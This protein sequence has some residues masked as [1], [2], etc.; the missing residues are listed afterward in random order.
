MPASRGQWRQRWERYRRYGLDPLPADAS[1]EQREQRIAELK[2]LAHQ[3]RRRIAMRSG[4][5]TL[6]I[7]LL[8]AVGVYW[9]VSTIGGRDFLLAQIKLRLPAGSEL[10]YSR[11][12]GPVRGPLILHDLRFIHRTCPDRDGEPVAWPGCSQ[13]RLI[14]FTAKQAM[15]HPSLRPLLGRTLFLRALEVDQATLSLP[16][17]D[18]KPFELPRWPQ[19]LPDIKPPMAL[20]AERIRVDG[21]QVFSA[22]KPVIDISHVQG[23]LDA[24]DGSLSLRD[25]VVDSDRGRFTAHGDYAPAQD[26]ATDLTVTAVLPAPPGRSRPHLGLV[27]RGDVA[28]L[29]VAVAGNVPGPLDVRLQLQGRNR[30][31]WTLKADAEALDISR[32]LQPQA[33]PAGQPMQISLQAEGSGGDARLQG[34]FRQGDLAATVQPSRLHMEEQR[35]RV[36]ELVVDVFEGRLNLHGNGDF[37]DPENARYDFALQARQLQWGAAEGVPI[38]ADADL[39][40]KGVRSDWN[41]D[42]SGVLLRDGLRADV[43][44][45]G[46]GDAEGM[47]LHKLLAT[48]PSGRLDASGRIGW[49]PGVSWDVDA[50]LAGFDP[51]YF[52]PGW[53]GAV[54][55]Q[56]ASNGEVDQAGALH[57]DVRIADLDGQLRGRALDGNGQL[58]IDGDHYRGDVR[59]AIG[60]SRIHAVGSISDRLDIDARFSPLQPGDLLPSASGVLRGEVHLSGARNAPDIRAQL[61][62]SGLAWNNWRAD[63]LQVNGRLPW[64]G[65]GGE[66]R[67]DGS[68]VQ[69]G[70]ALDQVSIRASG[71]VTALQAQADARSELGALQL[72]ASV[73]ERGGNWSGVLQQAV[74]APSVGARW[75]LGEPARFAQHGNGFTLSRSCFTSSDG[76]SLC[77]D[78]DW[79]RRGI[80][81]QGSALPLALAH[82]YLPELED[83][84]AWRMRGEIALE[85]RVRPVGNAWAGT[86]SV[87][88][89]PGGLRTEGSRYEVLAWRDIQ[90][91][92]QFNPQTIRASLDADIARADGRGDGGQLHATVATGWDAYAP[93]E[94][95]INAELTELGWIEL[96]SPDIVDPVGQLQARIALGGRCGQPS[97]GGNAALTGFGAEVPSLGLV[98]REGTARL[99]ALADG[100]ARIDG[101]LRSGEGVLA[102]NGSLGWRGGDTPLVLNVRG[103][104][105]TVSDTRDLRATADPDVVVRI[106]AGQPLD[107]SGTVTVRQALM[108]LQRLS[109]GVGRSPDVVVLD[110]VDP[111]R[112]QASTMRLDLTLVMGDDVRMRGFGLDGKLD[113]RLRVLARPGREMQGSGTLDVEG[114]YTAYGQRLDITRGRL[115]W[116]NAPISEPLLDVRAEREIGEV[117]AGIAVTGRPSQLEATAYSNQGGSQTDA[118]SYLTLGR[119]MSGLTGEEARQVSAADAA[120][121]AGG[122]M[123]ASQ[124]GAQLGL[125]DAGIMHSRTAGSVFGIGRR[126]SP[127][128]YVGYGVSLLGTGQVLMLKY[129]LRRGF[130]VQIESGTVENRASVNWRHERGGPKVRPSSDV[131]VSD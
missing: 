109:E 119:P 13:P 85:G 6:A 77:A 99:E 42:G 89:G 7:L 95:Q 35:L 54:H 37:S 27:A 120:L 18:D 3:R 111:A 57:A 78:A 46:A 112:A 62:G 69:A 38:R 97:L 90:L 26:Y 128:L 81:I 76:G 103:S 60:G 43:Q 68:G 39:Q 82:A 88:A 48:M 96:F 31:T 21:L 126:L 123:L 102:I 15:L 61:Q 87:R 131:Q 64:R 29:D 65:G 25:L 59:L 104:N 116:S 14:T 125:D 28:D 91:D 110:P 51:G 98:L 9:I 106:Q 44:L 33:A 49:S 45:Q 122:S 113:G 74:V 83:G 121:A 71:A 19:S 53:N 41:V 86:A 34:S 8:M 118:L 22:G 32:L 130:D 23:E 4:L 5:G 79:P 52:V 75:Q 36:D 30:P 72:Q 50:Q 66:M 127:R 56:L 129:M 92:A 55:G 117:R 100:T 11:A 20:H 40:L 67:I 105:I 10:H 101:R 124:L 80:D 58:R 115:V 114:R 93:L 108:D 1:A 70:L 47:R 2:R 17:A 12:E 73:N 84:T 107:V 94:G 16:E 63:S 24:R